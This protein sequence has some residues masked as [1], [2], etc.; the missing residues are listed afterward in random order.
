MEN[1]QTTERGERLKR[2]DSE[3]G[4]RLVRKVRDILREK[5]TTVYSISQDATAYD[6]LKL[7]AEKNIGALVVFDGDR[8]AGMI[9]VR[10]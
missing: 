7:M 2:I 5:G 1:A 6:A 10:D 4:E 9:S 8:L 3:M